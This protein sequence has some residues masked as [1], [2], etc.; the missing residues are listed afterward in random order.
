[1]R[2]FENRLKLLESHFLPKE[3][4]LLILNYSRENSSYTKVYVDGKLHKFNGGKDSEEV[5]KFINQVKLNGKVFTA[6]FNFPQK[7]KFD[8]ND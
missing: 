3:R 4:T 1:M 7:K 5:R 6:V 8:E 2:N